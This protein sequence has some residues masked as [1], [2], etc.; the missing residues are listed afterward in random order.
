MESQTKDLSARLASLKEELETAAAQN[1]AE[2]ARL[3]AK[4]GELAAAQ[5]ALE[6]RAREVEDLK[7][8]LERAHAA[9]SAKTNEI[10][11]ADDRALELNKEIGRYRR[12]TEKLERQKSELVAEVD[13]LRMHRANAANTVPAVPTSSHPATSATLQPPSSKR[14]FSVLAEDTPGIGTPGRKR[15]RE[16]EEDARPRPAEARRSPFKSRENLVKNGL[17]GTKRKMT[18]AERMFAE[19]MARTKL[20]PEGKQPQAANPFTPRARDGNVA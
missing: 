16:D 2:A 8:D 20:A 9:L 6:D 3:S 4:D 15:P 13:A 7:E 19:K 17:G 14:A 10:D 12:K 18:S 11:E 5:Q 1:S